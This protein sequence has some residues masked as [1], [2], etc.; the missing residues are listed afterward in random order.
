MAEGLQRILGDVAQ[1]ETLGDADLD[2]LT[3]MRAMIVSKLRQP[4]QTM[5]GAGDLPSDSQPDPAAMAMANAGPPGAPQG[6]P[7]GGA[8]M[9]RGGLIPGPAGQ[10]NPDE[11][12]RMLQQ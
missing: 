9:M 11:L 12:R 1:M 4:T 10:P 8:Q 2:F 5:V 6:P 3:E 7:P